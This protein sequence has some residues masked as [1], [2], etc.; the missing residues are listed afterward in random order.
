MSLSLHRLLAALVFPF[1]VSPTRS[2]DPL[3]RPWRRRRRAV[4]LDVDTAPEPLL[5]D[6]GILDGRGPSLRPGHEHQHG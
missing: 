2:F 1:A 6:L 3:A 4:F 5:R